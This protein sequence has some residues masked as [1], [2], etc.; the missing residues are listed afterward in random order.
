MRVFTAPEERP[1]ESASPSVFLAGSIDQGKASDWQQEVITALDEIDVDVFNPRRANW[2]STWKQSADNEQFAEQVVWELDALEDATYKFFYFEA[3]SLSP[4]T[5]LEYGLH[6]SD[7]DVITVCPEG[8]W[9]RGNIEIVAKE[10]WANA[11]IHETLDSG[12]K[13]LKHRLGPFN[14]ETYLYK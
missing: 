10:Y 2:D 8:F 9:R 5:M 3:G 4:V 1:Y 13:E 11:R 7:R 12:V 6:I 14:H